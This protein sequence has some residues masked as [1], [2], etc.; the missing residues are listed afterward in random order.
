VELRPS[1]VSP[2]TVMATVDPTDPAAR[3]AMVVQL[4]EQ[5]NRLRKK[6]VTPERERLADTSLSS[7]AVIGWR[8]DGRA[9]T[10]DRTT[11]SPAAQKVV[12]RA[13]ARTRTPDRRGTP[14]R[15]V[16]QA[17]VVVVPRP[18]ATPAAAQKRH[19]TPDR[20]VRATA[21]ARVTAIA[22]P[23][24][25]LGSPSPSPARAPVPV[26]ARPAATPAA[27]KVRAAAPVKRAVAVARPVPSRQ[28][29][30]PNAQAS[31]SS[32]AEPPSLAEPPTLEGLAKAAAQPEPQDSG[33]AEESSLPAAT[34]QRPVVVRAFARQRGNGPTPTVRRA[35]AVA[36]ARRA[37]TPPRVVAA[38]SKSKAAALKDPPEITGFTSAAARQRHLTATPPAIQPRLSTQRSPLS[39]DHHAGVPAEP[40]PVPEPEPEP[41]PETQLDSGLVTVKLVKR[42]DNG[43]GITI[44]ESLTICHAKNT[45]Y[46]HL[47][48]AH[49]ISV[50][51]KRYRQ[52]KALLNRL[53]RFPTNSEVSS[54]AC[55]LPAHANRHPPSAQP[56]TIPTD[57]VER[58][59]VL[60]VRCGTRPNEH[61]CSTGRRHRLR[62]CDFDVTCATAPG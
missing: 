34:T 14:P 18:A 19:S 31:S 43:F 29:G 15:R 58:R 3:R 54:D 13:T 59:R 6:F 62:R 21:K 50:N 23:S 36:V 4:R 40:K 37:G 5:Q 60:S 9:A 26:V 22:S 7:P 42:D 8:A 25:A 51:G 27:A 16:A 10:P 45:D 1:R 12:V 38:R 30:R 11:S 35:T 32:G 53:R 41:E 47:V 56:R 57:L 55:V 48:G 24:A 44:D 20:A 39:L 33:D 2:A 52:W 46:R 17:A 28:L 49:V 61:Q